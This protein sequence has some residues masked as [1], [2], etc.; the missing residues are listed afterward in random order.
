MWQL[1]ETDSASDLVQQSLDECRRVFG[2]RVVIF[3]NSAG[4]RDD[5]GFVQAAEIEAQLRIAVL[6]HNEKVCACGGYWT[7]C[8]YCSLG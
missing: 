1:G 4:S 2:D 5:H 6:Q 8:C 7:C 3:S